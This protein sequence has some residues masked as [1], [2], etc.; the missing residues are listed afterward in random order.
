[1]IKVR[2]NEILAA[3]GMSQRQVAIKA[4]VRPNTIG[5]LCKGE[6]QRI[7]LDVLNRIC[8]ALAMHPG[9]I[10]DWVPDKETTPVN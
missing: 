5:L 4:N 8:N 3:K 7:D 6:V 1:M 9:E 10:M 2:L